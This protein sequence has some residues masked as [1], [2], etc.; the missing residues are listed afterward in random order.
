MLPIETRDS[1][2]MLLSL[3][4][5]SMLRIESN[6]HKSSWH[7]KQFHFLWTIVFIKISRVNSYYDNIKKEVTTAYYFWFNI[8]ILLLLGKS[9]QRNNERCSILNRSKIL[10]IFRITR[11]SMRCWQ[12]W[13]IKC[14]WLKCETN[15]NF[16]SSNL[17]RS[18][19]M[20]LCILFPYVQKVKLWEYSQ[21]FE[22]LKPLFLKPW[23]S[24]TIQFFASWISR[25]ELFEYPSRSA[26]AHWGQISSNER[27]SLCIL[28]ISSFTLCLF[29]LILQ[30]RTDICF[31]NL[32]LY[33]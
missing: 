9:F 5:E 16:K 20:Y 15:S 3:L 7:R 29:S 13:L 14:L 27:K 24:P 8:I 28:R 2:L 11:S 25:L 18:V 17:R 22:H 10:D 32:Q 26:S 33:E 12:D 31:C 19:T 23:A 21:H 30:G 6:D 1:A 4:T